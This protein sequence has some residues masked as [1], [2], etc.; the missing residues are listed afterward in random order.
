MGNPA[1]GAQ[2]PGEGYQSGGS[3][4]IKTSAILGFADRKAAFTAWAM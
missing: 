3:M 1:D 2:M 4:W